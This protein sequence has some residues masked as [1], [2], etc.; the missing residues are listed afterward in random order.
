M[1]RDRFTSYTIKPRC[2]DKNIHT[3]KEGTIMGMVIRVSFCQ[4]LAPSMLAAS[5]ISAGTPMNPAT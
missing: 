4:L 1:V 3:M 2:R 5:P